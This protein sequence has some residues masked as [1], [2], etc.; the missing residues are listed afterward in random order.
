V[1]LFVAGDSHPPAAG[2]AGG[3]VASRIQTIQ[4]LLY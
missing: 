2:S 3:G 1:P 4:L